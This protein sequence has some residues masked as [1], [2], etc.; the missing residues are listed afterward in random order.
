MA[1]LSAM[2]PLP[3]AAAGAASDAGLS[4]PP[5]SLPA[6]QALLSGLMRDEQAW[7]TVADLVAE[8]DFYVREHRLIFAALRDLAAHDCPR[9]IVTLSEWLERDG[10][11]ADAGG[12]PYLGQVVHATGSAANVK[13]YATLVR[14]HSVRHQL[15]SVGA[16]I[17]DIA[18]QPATCGRCWTRRNGGSSPSPNRR[19]AAAASRRCASC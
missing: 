10:R 19:S 8:P 3:P 9:D 7:D 2:P 13:A 5:Y 11:L 15:I 14:E 6:E 16:G 12:L 18:L 4:V 17:S 1:D